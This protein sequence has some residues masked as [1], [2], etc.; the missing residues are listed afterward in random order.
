MGFYKEDYE[1]V[2]FLLRNGLLKE[3]FSVVEFGS[4]DLLEDR[5]GNSIHDSNNRKS[6]REAYKK[7]TNGLYECI[8]LEGYHGAHKFDLGK[9]ISLEY[10]YNKQF[11]FVTCKDVGHWIFNQERLFTNLHNLCKKNGVI[12]WRSPIGAGFS[13]GWYSYHHYKILQ[14]AFANNYL[15]LSEACYITEYLHAVM[16][17]KFKNFDRKTAELIQMRNA[18]DF[19]G[20]VEEYAGRKDSW[21]YLPISKGLPSVSVTLLFLKQS[22][23][24]FRVPSFWYARNEETIKRNAK[25]VLQNC[26]PSAQ[27][28]KIAI[29]GAAYAGKLAKIFADECELEVLCFIDDYK[30]GFHEGKPVVPVQN[31]KENYESQCDFVL[32]G[33]LQNGSLKDR[34]EIELCQL[35][36]YWFVG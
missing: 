6:A 24:E 16:D 10:G 32:V 33:P 3:G 22:E 31:F 19:V 9:D 35:Q 36:T 2:E 14:L 21:R 29:F 11:D 20:A 30:T 28:G 1:Q 12:A 8:D 13:Q 23:E 5:E 25:S 4:Q 27:K 15:V 7:Y 34:V 26:F 17:G 18:G